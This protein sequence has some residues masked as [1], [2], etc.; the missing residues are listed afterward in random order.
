[1]KN[2]LAIIPQTY[3]M[4]TFATII[5][6]EFHIIR[7]E[8]VTDCTRIF[9]GDH[10]KKTD[11]AAVLID[12]ELLSEEGSDFMDHIPSVPFSKIPIIAVSTHKPS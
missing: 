5:A 9:H 7:V 3:E 8:S 12:F 2:I 10:D 11:I 1:M 4:D 6:S